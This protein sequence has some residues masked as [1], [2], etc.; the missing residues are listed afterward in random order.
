MRSFVDRWFEEH[1][2]LR[3][4]IPDEYKGLAKSITTIAA[5]FAHSWGEAFGK[6]VDESKQVLREKGA[7][8]ASSVK[9]LKEQAAKKLAR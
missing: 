7:L 2:Y 5:N 3:D 4:E 1:E 6:K 8:F 9:G